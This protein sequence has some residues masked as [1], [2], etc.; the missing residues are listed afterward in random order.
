METLFTPDEMSLI[1]HEAPANGMSVTDLMENA[2]RA[3][4]R[5]IRRRHHPCRVLV[6]TG[7][8]NNG[9]DGYVAARHLEDAGWPVTV[10][11]IAP[12]RPGSAAAQAA[13]AWHGLTVPPDIARIRAADLVIDA[14]F[15]AGLSRPLD[16]AITTLL[17]AAKT[18]IAIDIPSGVDGA[19]GALRGH[20]VHA[21]RTI[22]FVARKPGHLLLPGKACCGILHCAD[23]G[24]P[25]AAIA[26]VQPTLWRNTPALWQLPTLARSGHKYDRGHLTILAGPMSGAAIL[27]ANAA[28]RTGVGLLTIAVTNGP[29]TGAAPGI[30]IRNDPLPDLLT[31]PRR[32]TWL[33]GPGL[34]IDHARTAL[35]TLIAAE[36]RILADAD[37]LTACAGHPERLVGVA[38]ITPHEGEFARIFP[39]LT[40]DKLTRARAAASITGAIVVLKGEDTVIAAPDGRAAINDNA[41]PSLATA[42]SGDTLAGIIAGLLTQGMPEFEA[43]CAG[44]WLHG[45]AANTH[46]PGLIA[47]DL[48]DAIPTAL[49]AALNRALNSARNT[50]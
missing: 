20:P 39:D 48:A 36:R 28:R 7:P 14:I 35:A 33:C 50:T 26:R 43:A 18:L 3:V 21:H 37:A 6:L 17:E 47:E 32:R 15:G 30:M 19:T 45:A 29:I 46:G 31:D 34:G 16:P 8:G 38:I 42:G 11:P 1:D 4:A 22:T 12:P 49:A 44:V 27:A 40:G 41:P 25:H 24:M 9:G 23:I 2:G 13:A 10:A 5:I